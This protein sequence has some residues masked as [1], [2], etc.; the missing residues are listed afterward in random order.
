MIRFLSYYIL[1]LLLTASLLYG[2]I[3]QARGVWLSREVLESG[4]EQIEKA[5][6]RLSKA[7]FNRIFVGVYYLGGTIYPSDVVEQAGG[8][9]QL[10]RF[11]GRDPLAE[12]IEIAHRWNLEVVAWFEYGLMSYYS[13]SDT[14]DS[15]PVLTKHPDWE[16][17]DHN[18][19]HYQQNKYGVFHWMDAA[20]PEVKQFTEDLFAEIARKYPQL[21]AIE[22]DRIRYP[23]SDFSYSSISRQRYQET[24][25]GSDPLEI[26]VGH[27]E[28]QQW[29]SWREKQINQIAKRIYEAVKREQPSVLVSAA[30]APPYMLLSG[31]KL[32]RWDVWSDSG[33][34]DAVEPMLYLNDVDFPNQFQLAKQQTND[35]VLL[36][37]G[38]DFKSTNSL[39]YQ[40]RYAL[41]NGSDGVTIWYYEDLGDDILRQIKE[42]L[43][44]EKAAL[45][46]QDL[47]MD[48]RSSRFFST[49]GDWQISE[50]GFNGSSMIAAASADNKAFYNPPIWLAGNYAMFAYWQVLPENTAQAEFTV[51]LNDRIIT[52]TVDQ[53]KQG[54][55]WIFLY[56]D[57]MNHDTQLRIELT[58]KGSGQLVADAFRLLKQRP[59]EV[60]DFSLPDSVHLN[61]QFNQ[62]ID[63]VSASD[64]SRYSFDEGIEVQAAKFSS[65]DR[66]TVI[67]RTTPFKEGQTYTLRVEGLKSDFGQ[68][69]SDVSFSFTY[70]SDQTRI[71]IDNGSATFKAYGTWESVSDTAGVGSDCLLAPAGS[72]DLRAQWW[73]TIPKDG[74]YQVQAFIPDLNSANLSSRAPYSVLHNFGNSQVLLDQAK[75]AGSWA[76]LGTYFFKQG[77]VASVQVSN[78]TTD[79]QVVADA[80]RLIR[81]LNPSAVSASESRPHLAFKAGINYPNPFNARTTIPFFLSE[82]AR[83]SVRIFDIRGRCVKTV[84][85]QKFSPGSHRLTIDAGNLSSG[86]YF[87][88][89]S[90]Q[91]MNGVSQKKRGKMI[92]IK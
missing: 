38:I 84:S 34:V 67:L 6:Y 80:V 12:T 17:V 72:G 5:C 32:Q 18:G 55:R 58:N 73:T 30:V 43:F 49:Q 28:W 27:P 21:D 82:S 20:H 92:L 69:L 90:V 2:G 9:R 46:H 13:G 41:E 81:T 15:G 39:L 42:E 25:G 91:T 1:L 68:P 60:K 59:F 50:G 40:M 37:S 8:P 53:Q 52:R 48:D 71:E 63:S 35:R 45:P 24:T 74:Y 36:Y 19:R 61:V 26:T 10:S 33:Y 88:S 11:W 86:V 56:A 51:H 62:W 66:A 22:T 4:P 76:D 14:S 44:S 78:Q 54:D 83:V 85:S 31:D 64:A 3:P 47:I 57:S 77:K 70:L 75:L 29:I 79:G 89:I 7:N 23:S 65:E 87:Y 16:A